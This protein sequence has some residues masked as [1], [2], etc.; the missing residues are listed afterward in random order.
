M[1]LINASPLSLLALEP[2]EVFQ[3]FLASLSKQQKKRL[4][5][6]WRGWIARPDQLAPA[7]EW[8]TWLIL[9]GRGWGKTRSG[10]EWVRE[11]VESGRCRRFAL[12]A[13][14]AADARNVMVEGES[15]ILAISP[16]SFRPIY[17]PSKRL[18]TWPNG[19]VA[20]TY[21]GDESNQLRGPQHDGAWAD[22]PAKWKQPTETW[23]NLEFGLRLGTDPRIVATTT[24][25][26][27]PLLRELIADRRT[28]VTRG[29]T[30]DN[31]D[32]LA[33]GYIARMREKYE[34]T[35]LGRQELYAELLEDVPGA[36]WTHG[37]LGGTRVAACPCEIYRI[38]VAIDPAVSNHADSNETGIMVVGLGE[39]GDAYVLEDLSGRFSPAAW[40]QLAVRAYHHYTADR[41]IGEVNNGGDLI[42]S[43]LRAV[44]AQ[45]SFRS[46]RASRGK[47][48]RAEPVA[49][50]YERKCVHHVGPFLELEEQMC[51]YV[52]GPACGSPDRLDALVWAITAL[53]I[54]AEPEINLYELN[55]VRISPY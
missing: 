18:L 30:Y 1:N 28:I 37:L 43:T 14:T 46:V 12:V 16:P 50:L 21:S 44:D 22:E 51:A 19:A 11:Q 7:G 34:G 32:N 55:R 27:I 25:R 10:A 8:Q 29:S 39:D 31:S 36:L 41:I 24:P 52:P 26:P 45:V 15:G 35:R 4:P 42:E 53:I 5:H 54:D 47:Y 23:N 49:A 48:L 2:P 17:E 13:E 40:A 33:P 3:A 9:A 38:V 6:K 20:T